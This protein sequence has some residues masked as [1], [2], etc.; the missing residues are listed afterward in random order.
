MLWAKGISVADVFQTMGVKTELLSEAGS[1]LQSA[2]A[3]V[4]SL[5]STVL[6][7][8]KPVFVAFGAVAA[9]V[10]SA[11]LQYFGFLING[12]AAQLLSVVGAVIEGICGAFS[13][14]WQMP[15]VQL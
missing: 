7:G 11:V 9:V 14:G 6:T 12:V 15:L 4:G 2:F 8:L 13:N 3:A 10:I 1:A 5:L